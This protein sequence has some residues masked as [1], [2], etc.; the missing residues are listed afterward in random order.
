LTEQT[1]YMVGVPVILAM[2]AIELAVSLSRG[3][4]I[5]EWSDTWGSTGLLVGNALVA[6]AV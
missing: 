4:R 6:L 1:V 5:Y 3:R 2:I